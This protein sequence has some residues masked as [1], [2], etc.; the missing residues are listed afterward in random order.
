MGGTNV[1]IE[2][3]ESDTLADLASQAEEIL[4][5]DYSVLLVTPFPP[6]I[7]ITRGQSKNFGGHVFL[8][9]DPN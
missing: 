2:E 6:Q 5:V 1:F 9:G 7:T 8:Y 4:N 3:I